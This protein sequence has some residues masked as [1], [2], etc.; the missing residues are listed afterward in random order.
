VLVE[1]GC[2]LAQGY[3]IA[4]PMPAA[5]VPDWTDQWRLPGEWANVNELDPSDVNLLMAEVEHRQWLRELKT[6][7]EHPDHAHPTM[8]EKECKFGHWLERPST[9]RRLGQLPA[10]V[11]LVHLHR[12]FHELATRLMASAPSGPA[13]VRWADL[14][15]TS[16]RL[17]TALQAMK[18]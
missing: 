14:E 8:S 4:R 1:L 7:A 16:Q 12:E 3:A 13:D 9:V 11:Q 17:V 15:Q 10:F 6:H 18:T 5:H 2:E